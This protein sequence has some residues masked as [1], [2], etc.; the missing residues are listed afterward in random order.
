MICGM[1]SLNEVGPLGRLFGYT[2]A[3]FYKHL[4]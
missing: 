4:L 2:N 1:I 3:E